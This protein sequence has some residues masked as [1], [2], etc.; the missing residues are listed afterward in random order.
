MG[1]GWLSIGKG[2]K[3]LVILKAQFVIAIVNISPPKTPLG[4][5][6]QLNELV[7]LAVA[8][9]ENAHW[10]EDHE[11]LEESV[12]KDCQRIRA[13]LGDLGGFRGQGFALDRMLSG[14]GGNSMIGI[15]ANLIQKGAA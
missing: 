1:K 12:R 6:L 9:W 8:A 11:H 14:S 7:V 3:E 15:S 10:V 2:H 5:S 4:T 13:V